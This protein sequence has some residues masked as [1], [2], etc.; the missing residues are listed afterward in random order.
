MKRSL[1]A[2]VATLL[3]SASIVAGP[4]VAQD[5]DAFVQVSTDPALGAI[6]TDSEG[7]TL[8]LFTND[9]VAGESAC[10]DQCAENWPPLEPG[11]DLTLQEGVPGELSVI[12]RDDGTQQVAYNGIPLY[13]WIN[14]QE[15][16][17]TTG[18]A[19][20]GV[21][22]VVPPGAQHGDYAP[23]ATDA[24][25]PVPGPTLQLGF[26]PELGAYFVDATGMTVYLFT[27]DTEA[28]QSTC[29]DQCAE[30]WPPVVATDDMRLPPG[31]PGTLGAIDR[32][33]GIT[34]VTYNDIPL[35]TWI[36]DEQP[37]DTTGQGVGDVWYVVP[38]GM[39]LGDAVAAPEATP[40]A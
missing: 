38:P 22:F 24:A 6:L 28:G 5:S 1:I 10:Y 32:D 30:N 40:A 17:D 7:M 11:D 9:T 35:Y 14:D 27:N 4:A 3:L 21:W 36:N 39:M 2:L 37:G 34:Q 16:G 29:Y 18:Q 31:V 8:Y 26:S 25:T 33:D 12:D 20:G 23:L 15:P 19:V 13:Y